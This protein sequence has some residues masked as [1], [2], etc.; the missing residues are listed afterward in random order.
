M[1]TLIL[2]ISCENIGFAC[3]IIDVIGKTLTEIKL[4]SKIRFV[5]GFWASDGKFERFWSVFG[6]VMS[7]IRLNSHRFFVYNSA[8]YLPISM[9]Y[10]QGFQETIK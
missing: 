9:K 2:K 6:K 3:L 8:I 1:F 7:Q 10:W 5:R 4:I